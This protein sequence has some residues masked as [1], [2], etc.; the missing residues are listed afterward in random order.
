MTDS[1]SG[2]SRKQLHV[3]A[4]IERKDTTKPAYWMRVGS[5][6]S[7]R[8]GSLTLYL[9]A[10]PVGSNKLQVREPRPWD[11]DRNGAGRHAPS[12]TEAHP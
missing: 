2:S 1:T 6:F 5:A 10:F 12:E 11:E 9:D 8:D 4:I 3:F 7:N